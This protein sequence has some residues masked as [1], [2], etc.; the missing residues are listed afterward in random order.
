M[1]EMPVLRSEDTESA[2]DAVKASK[3]KLAHGSVFE[4]R[5]DGVCMILSFALR[6]K[7]AEPPDAK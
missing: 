4:G 1:H 7:S 5:A 3:R 6:R 2:R